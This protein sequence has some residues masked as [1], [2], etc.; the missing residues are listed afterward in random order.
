[1][2]RKSPRL[3]NLFARTEG[4]LDAG[5]IKPIGVGLREGEIAALEDIAGSLDIPRNQ[6]LRFAIRHFLI[7]YQAGKIDLAEYIEQ[8]PPPKKTL[9][10]PD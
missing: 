6:I 2:A 5:N 10:L 9:R 7:D 8:P 3:S 4:D 1:M